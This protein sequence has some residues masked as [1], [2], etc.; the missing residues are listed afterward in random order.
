[1]EINTCFYSSFVFIINVVVAFYCNYYLYAALFLLLLVTS[2]LYHC[3]YTYLTNILDKIAI[4]SIVFYGG[5]VFYKRLICSESF[6]IKQLILSLLIVSTFLSSAV[7]YYYGYLNKCL[8]FCNDP[9]QANL[10][11]SLVHC[12]TCI[13]HCCIMVL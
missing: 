2:L 5:W 12:V 3:Q 13:G 10:F 7:L 4:F 11:H 1:M 6:N 8:C 9:T